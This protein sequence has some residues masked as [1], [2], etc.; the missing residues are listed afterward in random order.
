MGGTR[1]DAR[2]VSPDL[3]VSLF[4]LLFIAAAGSVD[5]RRGTVVTPRNFAPAYLQALAHPLRMRVLSALRERS[6]SATE[7]ARELG[8]SRRQV[9]YHVEKMKRLGFVS[10]APP[11][12]GSSERRFQLLAL[13]HFTDEAWERAAT[14]TKH[15]LAT[16][17]VN[18]IH[19]TALAVIPF[20][21]FD[22]GNMHLTRTRL[23]VDEETWDTL[24]SE[25]LAML[26]RIDSLHAEGA[27]RVAEDGAAPVHATAAMMLFETPVSPT[28]HAI[29]EFVVDPAFSE[30]EGHSRALDL[31]DE[32]HRVLATGRDWDLA[33]NLVDQL[34]VVMAA[35]RAARD[36]GTKPAD[37]PS[38]PAAPSL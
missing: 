4:G 27:R 23:V 2:S 8:A 15:A 13:P 34:R 10:D 22:R 20:G 35:G 21:G 24:S 26:E 9:A 25:L 30:D 1:P 5:G 37:A 29:G 17:F 18:Q 16:A 38:T 31:Q 32:L 6:L 36:R 33:I 19:A 3:I 14:I 11:A 28:D 12:V 7:L